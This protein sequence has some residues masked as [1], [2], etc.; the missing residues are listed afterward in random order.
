MWGRNT[1]HRVGESANTESSRNEDA[2]FHPPAPHPESPHPPG[3]TQPSRQCSA[4]PGSGAVLQGWLSASHAMPWD[5]VCLLSR[6]KNVR[7]GGQVYTI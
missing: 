2:C 1:L 3:V 7:M 6:P 4:A 5:R